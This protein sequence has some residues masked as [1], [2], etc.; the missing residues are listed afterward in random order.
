MTEIDRLEA[1]LAELMRQLESSRH[2]G[3]YGDDSILKD[4]D[5]IVRHHVYGNIS[6]IAVL[7][8][9]VLNGLTELRDIDRQMRDRFKREPIE[10]PRPLIE[11]RGHLT[12]LVKIQISNML[13]ILNDADTLLVSFPNLRKALQK[14][15]LKEVERLMIYRDS[16]IVH[17]RPLG[18]GL[19]IRG[20][21]EDG[22][23]HVFSQ[24]SI[25]DEQHARVHALYE[26][27][28]ALF[29][30]TDRDEINS[31]E[32]LNLIFKNYSLVCDPTLI[33][34]IKN[35]IGNI[36]VLSPQPSE[37]VSCAKAVLEDVAASAGT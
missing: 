6:D 16:V 21:G 35:V 33:V 18:V 13:T 31:F 3:T 23:F 17:K 22:T 10:I 9:E 11:R 15:T 32:Q 14:P 28:K 1:A 12:S 20:G 27:C 25:P 7:A 5:S 26:K 19:G 37:I 24:T 4:R 30:E 2:I 29:P 36:G 34:E 8:R